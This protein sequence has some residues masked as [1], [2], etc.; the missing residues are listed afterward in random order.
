LSNRGKGKKEEEESLN[1]CFLR[2]ERKELGPF[3]P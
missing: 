2:G 3:A 1:P